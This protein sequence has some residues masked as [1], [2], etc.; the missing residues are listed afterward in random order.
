M[1][2]ANEII[3]EKIYLIRGKKVMLD[4]DLAKL[5]GVPTHRLNEAVKRNLRRFPKDFM[6]HLVR[7]EQRLISQSAISSLG[8]GGRRKLPYVIAEQGIAMLSSVLHS[9]RAIQV[10][11]QIMRAF[12]KLREIIH[13]HGE[14]WKKIEEMEK[15]YNRNFKVVFDA[16]RNLLEPP[17]KFRRRIGFH[18]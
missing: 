17:P 8:W 15:K 14:L 7:K 10:N 13:A 18:S 11:I 16:L 9:E 5:Y 6:F 4:S 2:I 3:H 12:T 1:R